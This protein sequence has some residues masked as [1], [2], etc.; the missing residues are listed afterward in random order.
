VI[1]SKEKI[2]DKKDGDK[3]EKKVNADSGKIVNLMASKSEDVFGM[4]ADNR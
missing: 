1:A 4:S 3:E 2:E